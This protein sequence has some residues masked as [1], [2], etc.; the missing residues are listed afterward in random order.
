MVFLSDGD[1]PGGLFQALPVRVQVQFLAQALAALEGADI[2]G[3][4][5]FHAFAPD[6]NRP[7]MH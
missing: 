5:Q 2:H 6:L 4:P 1:H 3:G 7:L